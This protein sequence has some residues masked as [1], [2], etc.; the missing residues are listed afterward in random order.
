MFGFC[1]ELGRQYVSEWTKIDTAAGLK[2]QATEG[3]GASG[4]VMLL[5]TLNHF[6][7]RRLQSSWYFFQRA[8]IQLTNATPSSIVSSIF[9]VLAPAI[10]HSVPRL[11]LH[12]ILCNPR[13][14]FSQARDVILSEKECHSVAS[15]YAS[16]Q[17]DCDPP[18]SQ[19]SK[20]AW[21]LSDLCSLSALPST[22]R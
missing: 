7:D 20:I 5:A 6:S 2:R 17:I 12:T 3:G 10:V 1:Q 19:S 16:S 4:S 8:V 15:H 22:T 21:I 11:V 9:A 14:Q 18:Y 13:I